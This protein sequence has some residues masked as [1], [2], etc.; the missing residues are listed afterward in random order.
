VDQSFTA[1]E[2]GMPRTINKIP[3]VTGIRHASI[4]NPKDARAQ[5]VMKR[6]ARLQ[7]KTAPNGSTMTNQQPE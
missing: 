6:T 3:P 1:R 5:V 2:T 4:E 7:P